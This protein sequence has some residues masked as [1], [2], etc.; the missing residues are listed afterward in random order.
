MVEHS[1]KKIK[2]K[3]SKPFIDAD[4]MKK[5]VHPQIRYK[6]FMALYL[7]PELY[8][9]ELSKMLN[10]DKTTVARHLKKMELEKIVIS[11]EVETAGK[12][13]RKYYSLSNN[14]EFDI[15]EYRKFISRKGMTKVFLQEK[16][17]MKAKNKIFGIIRALIILISK[18]FELYAPIIDE[19]DKEI[20]GARSAK[21]FFEDYMSKVRKIDFYPI[22]ISEERLKEANILF[23]E[24]SEKLLELQRKGEE[25]GEQRSM[26]ILHTLMPLKDVLT[27]FKNKKK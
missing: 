4:L 1:N 22:I 18:G 9:T 10:L 20:T 3:K 25:A 27:G 5:I 15:Q 17:V 6:I 12:I 26:L 16:N 7:Y 24:Y 11:N 19:L 2:D 13:N 23:E 21:K 8:V 14:F